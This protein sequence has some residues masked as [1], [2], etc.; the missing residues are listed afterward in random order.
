M[1]ARVVEGAELHRDTGSD[2]DQGGQSAFVEGEG[3]L[4]GEDLLAAVEGGSV[5]VASLEAHFY[6]ICLLTLLGLECWT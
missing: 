6:D 4:M 3:P 5:L 1:P 2:P